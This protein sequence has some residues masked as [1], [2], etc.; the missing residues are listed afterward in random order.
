MDD[1]FLQFAM[2]YA[3]KGISVVPNYAVSETGKCSCSEPECGY[4][5]KHSRLEKGI[6]PDQ[7]RR[8]GSKNMTQ[9]K[10]WWNEWPNSNIAVCTGKESNIVVVDIDPRNNGFNSLSFLESKF[11]KFMTLSVKSGGNGQHL[12]FKHPKDGTVRTRVGLLPGIDI[13]GENGR[14]VAPPSR[15]GS[16]G[17]YGF[18]NDF[19]TTYLQPLPMGLLNMIQVQKG[20]GTWQAMQQKPIERTKKTYFQM[21]KL[22]GGK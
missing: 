21:K 3:G 20:T 16:G 12:Y 14:I 4:P 13:K 9:I 7:V 18:M 1:V 5:G 19:E 10:A 6:H 22:L 8:Q 15:H 11:G 2:R 17:M